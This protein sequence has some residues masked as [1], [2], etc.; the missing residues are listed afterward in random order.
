MA[1]HLAQLNGIVAG[2]DALAID[3]HAGHP[4]RRRSGGDDDFA[5]RPERLL[6]ALE[7]FDSAAAG[8][9]RRPLDPVDLVLLEQELDAAGEAIDDPI[10]ARLHVGHV[11][12]HRRRRGSAGPDGHAPLARMLDDLQRVRVLEERLGGNTAPDQAGAAERLLLFH[13]GGGQPE[14]RGADCSDVSAG[15]GADHNDV[16]VACHHRL[17]DDSGTKAVPPPAG[18]VSAPGGAEVSGSRRFTRARSCPCS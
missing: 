5:A 2:D 18:G 8:Q 15:A 1:R 3:Q 10:L 9:P 12:R 17:S 13:D 11:D 6:V 16:V 7:H 14:L 4:A